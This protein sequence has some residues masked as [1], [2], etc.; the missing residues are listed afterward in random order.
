MHG[1]WQITRTAFELGSSSIFTYGTAMNSSDVDLIIIGAGAAGI[2]AAKRAA[3][4]GLSYKVLEASH[5]VGGRAYTEQIGPKR[6]PFDLGCHWLHSASLNPM[7]GIADEY[8][9]TY[10]TRGVGWR[11]FYIDGRRETNA[12]RAEW[13]A[14]YDA[15]YAAIH[16]AVAAGREASVA[17]LTPRE[18]RWTPFWDYIFSALASLDPDQVSATDLD[19]YNDTG[20]NWPMRDGYGALIQRFSADMAFELNTQVTRIDW[21]GQGVKAETRR[22]TVS[23][24]AAIIT[25]STGV[26]G[27][28]DILFDPAL[29]A[30]KISAIHHLPLGAHN[31]IALVFNRDV[32]DKDALDGMSIVSTQPHDVPMMFGLKPFGYDYAVGL[33]GGRYADWLERAGVEASVDIALEKLKSVFGNDIAKH[34]VAKNVSSWRGDPWVKGAY[35]AATPGHA[36][37]RNILREPLANRLFFAGEATHASFYS[38]CHG[39]YLSGIDAVD[40]VTSIVSGGTLAESGP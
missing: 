22:G 12:E 13:E 38:T 17:D 16:A 40:S 1:S 20:E 24:R 36:D 28:G 30:E 6:E 25:V 39:A 9:F 23:G 34:V 29:P 35:S 19:A 5:R 8:R 21:S 7:V 18:D 2:G 15:S 27:A 33:T 11:A 37:A 14:F 26:L 3:S 4:L 32:F 31:R 10:D